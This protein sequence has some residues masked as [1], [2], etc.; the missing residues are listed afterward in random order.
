MSETIHATAV[1]VG[2]RGILI[3]G[4]SGSGKS[5]LAFAL[6]QR[7]GRLVADDRVHLSACHNRLIATSPGAMSGKLE[8]RGRGL[9]DVP[10]ERSAVIRLVVDMANETG[11]ERL[12]GD[13]QLRVDILGVTLA[14]QPVPA[15]SDGAVLL[16]SAALHSLPPP[17]NMGLRT[18]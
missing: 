14:R 6:I 13:D 2:A 12:P 17:A 18:T 3:R 9:A 1:L 10:H 7:G 5:M 8:L 11:L 15:A 4:P 16:V